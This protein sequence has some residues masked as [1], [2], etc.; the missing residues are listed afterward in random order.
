MQNKGWLIFTSFLLI[1]ILILNLVMFA[2]GLIG[3]SE[4]NFIIGSY[5]GNLSEA[6]ATDVLNTRYIQ[7]GHVDIAFDF[8]KVDR[9]VCID[10]VDRTGEA[11]GNSMTPTFFSGN[12]QLSREYDPEV[13]ILE[14]GMIISYEVAGKG[15]RVMH[16]ISALYPEYLLTESDRYGGYQRVKYEDVKFIV[17]GVLYT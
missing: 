16:R 9:T 1:I 3:I 5:T 10:N 13:D 15:Q 14:E 7:S 12:T 6:M 17:L 11:W 8:D 2:T 4:A